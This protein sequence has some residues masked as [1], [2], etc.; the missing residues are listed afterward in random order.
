M[1]DMYGLNVLAELKQDPDLSSIPVILQSGSS[2]TNEIEK[3]YQLG[4]VAYIKKPYLR[5]VILT[6]IN[7]LLV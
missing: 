3:A 4:A 1:P 2:D 6:E 7:K 5:Q